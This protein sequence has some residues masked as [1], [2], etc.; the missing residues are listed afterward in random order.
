MYVFLLQKGNYTRYT[1]QWVLW[2][3]YESLF[4]RH[5][6]TVS[7]IGTSWYCDLERSPMC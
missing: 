2:D 7:Q 6:Y 3:M 5:I 4:I 1:K